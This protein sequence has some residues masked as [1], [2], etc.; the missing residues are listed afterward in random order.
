MA[1]MDALWFDATVPAV[2]VKPADE[3]PEATVTEAGTL[4][5]ELFED[6]D[7]AAPPERAEALSVAVQVVEA[8]EARLPDAQLREESVTAAGGGSLRDTVVD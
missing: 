6:N 1:V 5:S 8:P 7:T 4:S 3:A 2:A